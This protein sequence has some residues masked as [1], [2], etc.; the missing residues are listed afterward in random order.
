MAGS[1][2]MPAHG[3]FDATTQSAVARAVRSKSCHQQIRLQASHY[4]EGML[5]TLGIPLMSFIQLMCTDR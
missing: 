3:A 5:T 2:N 1:G 4:Y